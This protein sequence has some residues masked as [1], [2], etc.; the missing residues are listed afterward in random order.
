MLQSYEKICYNIL[1]FTEI[2]VGLSI[3]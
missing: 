1:H 2:F 3:L